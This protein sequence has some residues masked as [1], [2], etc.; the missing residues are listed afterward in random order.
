MTAMAA[1]A[2]A[3][4]RKAAARR[5]LEA[6]RIVALKGR[7]GGRGLEVSESELSRYDRRGKHARKASA[8]WSR[9]QTRRKNG[10]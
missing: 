6:R 9:F 10:V 1:N 4:N 5:L 3:N 7:G 8:L 2:V